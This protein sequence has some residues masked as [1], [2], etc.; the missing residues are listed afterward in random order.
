MAIQHV[1]G[2]KSAIELDKVEDDAEDG[3]VVVVVVVVVAVVI[4]VGKTESIKGRVSHIPVVVVRIVLVLL[5]V[6][7]FVGV[8]VVIVFAVEIVV[9]LVVETNK[10]I[11]D[12]NCVDIFQLGTFER[13]ELATN[14]FFFV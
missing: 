3:A 12:A 7:G 4:V 9:E 8:V 1:H 11:T 6:V 13:P 10:T 5:C 2:K 14:A